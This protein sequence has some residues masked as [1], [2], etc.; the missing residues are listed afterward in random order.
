MLLRDRM[1]ISVGSAGLALIVCVSVS[2]FAGKQIS[3]LAEELDQQKA[4][5]TQM[6]FEI[7]SASDVVKNIA[8]KV[9]AEI[10]LAKIAEYQ[11]ELQKSDQILHSKL[12]QLEDETQDEEL[13]N[14]AKELGVIQDEYSKVAEDE[15]KFAS[16]FLNKEANDVLMQKL[17]P[18]EQKMNLLLDKGFDKSLKDVR[19]ISAK[20]VANAQRAQI[21]TLVVA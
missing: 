17:K 21:V 9:P 13:Q 20:M 18:I 1:F 10:D 12:K 5:A 6:I 15:F 11:Q 4:S 16:Q 19:F 14:M 7:R 2:F 8:G 3:K